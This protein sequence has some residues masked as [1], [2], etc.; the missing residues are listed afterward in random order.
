MNAWTSFT[1]GFQHLFR[2]ARRVFS[3]TFTNTSHRNRID[4]SRHEHVTSHVCPSTGLQYSREKLC[5]LRFTKSQRPNGSCL[6]TT[7]CT[8]VLHYRGTRAG[9]RIQAC[10]AYHGVNEVTCLAVHPIDVIIGNRHYVIRNF[11]VDSHVIL[12][13]FKRN[14]WRGRRSLDYLTLWTPDVFSQ[15]SPWRQTFFRK[16]P[17]GARR[18]FAN[19]P[20]GARRFFESEKR[21]DPSRAFIPLTK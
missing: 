10:R 8:G 16:L 14:N 17:P 20:P 11:V 2:P 5:S 3:Q 21:R 4:D 6:E 15:T 19:F 1:A 7:K 13:P 9:R 12:F 18:F